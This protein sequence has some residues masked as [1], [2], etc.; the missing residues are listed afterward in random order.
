MRGDEDETEGPPGSFGLDLAPYLATRQLARVVERWG[1]IGS[2]NDRARV[3]ARLGAAAGTTVLAE[4]QTRGRGQ[5]GRSWHSPPGA[6]IYASFVVRPALPPSRAPALTLLAGVAVRSAVHLTTGQELAIKWPNDLLAEELELYGR[7]VA[8]L[9]VEVSADGRKLDHAVIGVG[10]N[11]RDVPRP[12]PLAAYA[13]SLEELAA[14]RGTVST[15][16]LDR[17]RLIAAIAGELERRLDELERV[18]LEWILEDWTEHAAGRGEL[19]TLVVDGER[20]RGELL[21]VADDG[22]LLLL[23]D[24][25]R[26]TFYRGE[27]HLPGAPERPTP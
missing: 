25:G 21:G 2:T 13:T 26:R 20:V 9:L 17:A 6:G 19:V 7:K 10:L 15:S 23:T 4:S 16:V 5:R 18:G 12:A 14:R 24:E 1:T 11:V 8:G 22:A 3:L 27:L